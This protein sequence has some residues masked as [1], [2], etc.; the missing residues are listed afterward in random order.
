MLRCPSCAVGNSPQVPNPK[1]LMP[2]ELLRAILEKA[3]REYQVGGV[4]LFNW[5]EPLLHPQLPELVRITRSFGHRCD[6]SSNLHVLDRIEEVLRSE[7]D[8]L[9]ISCSGF[10]Q[11]NYGL[12]HRGGD[13]EK[14]KANMKKLAEAVRKTGNKTRVH[15]LFHRYRTNLDDEVL[16]RDYCN[17]LGIELV[18]VWAYMTP[19]EKVLAY[20][21]DEEFTTLTSDDRA[22]IDR[23]LLP[24]DQALRE[25]RKHLAT[26]C[27]LRRDNMAVDCVGNV[28]LCCAIY[29]ASRHTIG[30]YLDMPLA[31]IQKA[32]YAHPT[33]RKCM[34][35]GIDV[36]FTYG[37]PRFASIARRNAP[38][39]Y[40]RFLKQNPAMEEI[41]AARE[42]AGR[43]SRI[44]QVI[45]RL[46]GRQ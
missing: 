44:R 7:P 31:D 27:P 1:G 33:C 29:D 28:Q 38:A 40:R 21:G 41:M 4:A 24:T 42:R 20:L 3:G 18:P 46:L 13:I 25:A 36:Y 17:S 43:P 5:T 9:R 23:L 14:V 37:S 22:I 10:T 30:S 35:A 39:R 2:P 6:L 32:K 34:A 45:R 11:A 16:M 12:T 15:M 8:S 26:D 19:V